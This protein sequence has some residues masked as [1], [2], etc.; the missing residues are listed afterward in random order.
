[1]KLI[2]LHSDQSLPTVLMT[3]RVT[4]LMMAG[5]G[6]SAGTYAPTIGGGTLSS[7]AVGPAPAFAIGGK[8]FVLV[9]NW[10]FGTNGTV[11]NIADMNANFQ[12]HDQFKTFNNG[13]NYGANVVVSDEAHALP[14]QPVEDSKNRVRQFLPD[15]LKTFIVPLGGA[16]TLVSK[17]HNAG[18]GSFQAQWTLPNGG[19]LL[20]RDILWE[21]R[22][23]YVAPPYFWF[24][25]WTAG[26]QWNKG[27]EIDLIESFGFDNTGIG[28]GSNFDGHAWHSD[29]VGGTETT[30][31]LKDWSAGMARNHI[32]APSYD[33]T[34]WHVWSWLY[35]KDNSYECHVDHHL[36]QS[37]TIHWT[38]GGISGGT[39]INM[40]FIF[41]AT[42]GYVDK[43]T[44]ITHNDFPLAASALR[45]T[46]FEFD[47]SRVYL[48]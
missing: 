38:L 27:A 45:G 41:D 43:P 6:L 5:T 31:Y 42:W 7:P 46:Y 29:P 15:S 21:S 20:N 22:V 37:G 19:A 30:S 10:D 3:L 1:M 2:H 32:P 13:G 18:C 36:V 4:T 44:N 8:G 33:A 35:R 23:R 40:N 39:P 17:S 14:G 34:Q 48:R 24:A 28:R 12:Y 47:Y 16:T 26:D 25:L 9:K 11:R